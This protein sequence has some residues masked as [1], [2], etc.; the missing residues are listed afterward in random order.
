MLPAAVCPFHPSLA[1]RKDMT[2]RPH[3]TL[4]ELLDSGIPRT[5][6]IDAIARGR[7][8]P[9][10]AGHDADSTLVARPRLL[11]WLA[12]QHDAPWARDPLLPR[13]T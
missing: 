10:I 2:G 8:G 6:L 5:E 7:L 12:D 1:D 13:S 4:R 3:H 9:V 11:A